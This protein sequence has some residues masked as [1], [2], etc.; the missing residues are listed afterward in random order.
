MALCASSSRPVTKQSAP[1]RRPVAASRPPPAG[2]G[3]YY[4]E[5][6]II[7]S[8]HATQRNADLLARAQLHVR[9]HTRL[10]ASPAAVLARG[11]ALQL[12]NHLRQA[13][14]VPPAR[15]SVTHHA[16]PQT[17]ALAMHPE[18][19]VLHLNLLRPPQSPMPHQACLSKTTANCSKARAS[20][21]GSQARRPHQTCHSR[22]QPGAAPCEPSSSQ[23]ARG[24]FRSPHRPAR[25]WLRA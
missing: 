11:C 6:M 20:L 24:Q 1:T 2:T 3:I 10:W 15:G 16:M 17:S 21:Q 19:E 8:I 7:L 4:N 5:S 13:L 22:N 23:P 14:L 25:P 12:S 9:Q 18:P